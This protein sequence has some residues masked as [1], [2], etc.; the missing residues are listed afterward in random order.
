[1]NANET[2]ENN[3]L[4]AQFLGYQQKPEISNDLYINSDK[5]DVLFVNQ[6]KFDSDYNFL[7]QVVEK[8]ES[9]GAVVTIG[10]MKTEI[11][12]LHP[13]KSYINCNISI[14]SGVKINHI[15]AACIEFVKWYN[16]EK[17]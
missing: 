10:R 14:A 16:A 2:T 17:F 11:Q 4:L 7:M 3:I 6:M 9:I 12:Y 1:M 5:K 15:Y 13:I 8:I